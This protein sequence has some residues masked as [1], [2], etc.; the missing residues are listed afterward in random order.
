MLEEMIL[1]SEACF[2]G[3]LDY[4]QEEENDQ[5]IDEVEKEEGSSGRHHLHSIA[6]ASVVWN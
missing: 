1:N 2:K 4:V 3:I 6:G 5:P